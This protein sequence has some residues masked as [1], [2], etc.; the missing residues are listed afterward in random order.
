[1]FVQVCT[2]LKRSLFSP[3]TVWVLRAELR[4]S[5]LVVNVLLG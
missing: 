3:S 5:D 2:Q 4:S 1:M